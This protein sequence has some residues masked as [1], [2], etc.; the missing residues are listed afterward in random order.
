MAGYWVFREIMHLGGSLAR[1]LGFVYL[2]I[3]VA[4]TAWNFPYDLDDSIHRARTAP[5]AVI[6][7][8]KEFYDAA[9][10][11][12][13][14]DSAYIDVEKNAAS[15]MGIKENLVRVVKKYG[16]T[17][18]KVL[19]VG[20]GTGQLQDIVEDYTGLDLSSAVRRYYHKPF[21]AASAT[22]MPFPDNSFDA[23]WSIW[24]LEH[25]PEPER[26]LQE[27][28]RVLKPGGV[29]F[30]APAWHCGEFLSEGYPF[31][32]YSD[33]GLG[34]KLIKASVPIRINPLFETLHW[35]PTRAIRLASTAIQGTPSRFRF[36]RLNA[37]YK[38]FWGPDSDAAVQL[39][40]F[41]TQLWFKTRGD[42]CLS[43]GSTREEL[44]DL[45]YEGL[46]IRKAK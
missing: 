30:L 20:S 18:K 38:E 23:M 3:A 6:D 46:V 33:F 2:P 15:I 39:D 17:G 29:I 44:L 27:M 43:C 25:I 22:D 16:M 24:V 35:Y 12:N 13:P 4:L 37:N 7:K 8:G 26:A 36:R 40:R 34:G 11:D 28:R 45:S 5:P 31:R 32:P 1:V 9:Y 19:E 41:E 42:E 21:V 10:V 14:V